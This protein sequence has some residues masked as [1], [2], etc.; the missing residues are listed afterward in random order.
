MNR[1]F[2]SHWIP[3]CD[4]FKWRIY[5]IHVTRQEMSWIIMPILI[6]SVFLFQ[7]V[8]ASSTVMLGG[9][10]P[11]NW[12]NVISHK[13]LNTSFHFIYIKPATESECVI[14]RNN[15]NNEWC[16]GALHFTIVEHFQRYEC[17]SCLEWMVFGRKNVVHTKTQ[18]S[19]VIRANCCCMLHAVHSLS[20]RCE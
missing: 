10:L 4:A 14:S 1:K 12:D 17:Q 9:K 3:Q 7:F 13:Y 19:V 8:S 20:L 6:R 11:S 5:N 18:N 2:I 16:T 15:S